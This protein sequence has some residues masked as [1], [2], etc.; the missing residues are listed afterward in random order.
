MVE[1]VINRDVICHRKNV[2]RA[3]EKQ[4]GIEIFD[5]D[6]YVKFLPFFLAPPELEWSA[7]RHCDPQS[8]SRITIVAYGRDPI[9]YQGW[10]SF[11]ELAIYS[12]L[13]CTGI[14]EW[15]LDLLVSDPPVNGLDLPVTELFGESIFPRIKMLESLGVTVKQLAD[16]SSPGGG[17]GSYDSR[18]SH[19]VRVDADAGFL[20]GVLEAPC[21]NFSSKLGY[22]DLN[23]RHT[24]RSAIEQFEKERIFFWPTALRRPVEQWVELVVD[25]AVVIQNQH[26]EKAVFLARM[27]KIPWMSDGLSYMTGEMAQIFTVLRNQ[28]V[29]RMLVPSWDE[30]SVKLA[31]VCLIGMNPEVCKVA[32]LEHWEYGSYT[33]DATVVNFRNRRSLGL[34]VRNFLDNDAF[35]G[36]SFGYLRSFCNDVRY[37]AAAG[38][39]P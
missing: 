16:L 6:P 24:G 36:E 26:L 23:F 22:S 10:L 4:A 13:H 30:E 32:V 1:I 8:K 35:V 9:S 18:T 3:I 5:K 33:P 21:F 29:K 11:A 12:I 37:R 28:L 14:E 31:L 2:M 27:Q 15:G 34:L 17:Y 39:R 38:R 20:P 19:V 25:A 7:A